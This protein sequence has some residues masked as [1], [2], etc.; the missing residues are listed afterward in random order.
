MWNYPGDGY[1]DIVAPTS[2]THEGDVYN[3]PALVQTGKPLA[4]AEYSPHHDD[5]YGNFNNLIYIS[6]ISSEYTGLAFWICWHDWSNGDGTNTYMSII[7]NENAYEL[8]NHELVITR[9]E[10]Q[11]SEYLDPV[12]P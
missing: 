8:M 12:I 7:N 3:Y 10:L 6:R 2:Y 9:D 11:L 5:N 4:M 1:I